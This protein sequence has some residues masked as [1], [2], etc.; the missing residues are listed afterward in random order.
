MIM[1]VAMMVSTAKYRNWIK[2]FGDLKPILN[3][4]KVKQTSFKHLSI[5]IVKY[6]VALIFSHLLLC[7]YHPKS[8]LYSSTPDIYP[9]QLVCFLALFLS[10]QTSSSSPHH[11]LIFLHSFN[12]E[13]LAFQSCR[14][15]AHFDIY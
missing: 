13:P 6:Q 7:T 11:Y 10:G 5:S 4:Y 14:E 1:W 8:L 9:S 2:Y 15:T 12:S 3:Y